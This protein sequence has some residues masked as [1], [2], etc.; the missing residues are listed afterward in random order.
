MLFPCIAT[1]VVLIRELGVVNMLKS[2]G[3]M[4]IAALLFGGLLN[5]VLQ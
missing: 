3:I 1:F 2:T 5:L 4:I